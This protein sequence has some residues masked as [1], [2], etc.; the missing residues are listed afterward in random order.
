MA[1]QTHLSLYHQKWYLRISDL[2][3]V[4]L[5][6]NLGQI[7]FTSPWYFPHLIC[8]MNNNGTNVTVRTQSVQ[9]ASLPV[10]LPTPSLSRNSIQHGWEWQLLPIIIDTSA[11]SMLDFCMICNLKYVDSFSLELKNQNLIKLY[12]MIW[13][14][15]NK[16]NLRDHH[17]KSWTISGPLMDAPVAQGYNTIVNSSIICSK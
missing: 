15:N 2:I 8:W 9:V 11:I 6:H 3:Y 4:E 5:W 1:Y 16:K 17:T 14:H 13:L 10:D 12:L 7:C